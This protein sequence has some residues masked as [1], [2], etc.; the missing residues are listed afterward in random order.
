MKV[1]CSRCSRRLRVRPFEVFNCKCGEEIYPVTSIAMEERFAS[2]DYSTIKFIRQAFFNGSSLE[3]KM[4]II[5]TILDSAANERT[6]KLALFCAIEVLRLV[7][8]TDYIDLARRIVEAWPKNHGVRYM[9]A[10]CLD[11]SNDRSDHYEALKQRMLGTAIRCY[12]MK[13]E[14]KLDGQNYSE[15]LRTHLQRLESQRQFLDGKAKY[16]SLKATLIKKHI[17]P[18]DEDIAQG[19]LSLQSIAEKARLPKVYRK[20]P[21]LTCVLDTNALSNAD[22]AYFFPSSMVRFIIPPEVLME[23]ANWRQVSHIPFNLHFVEVVPVSIGMPAEIHAM[24]CEG[25]NK[26]PSI[27]DKKVAML[28]IQE[29]ADAIVS[30]DCDLLGTGIPGFVEKQWGKRLSVVRPSELG[31]WIDGKN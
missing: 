16:P 11:L 15:V 21:K 7:E 22:T 1:T 14:N 18:A 19:I 5:R 28:A 20:E 30:A 31:K 4:G 13:R 17:S 10:N 12:E 6:K 26:L 24:R 27:T 25:R 3:T 8:G 29:R 23:L 9:Y 2:Y